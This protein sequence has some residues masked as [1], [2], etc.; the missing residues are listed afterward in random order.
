VEGDWRDTYTGFLLSVIVSKRTIPLI[1]EIL[2]TTR[3]QR[4]KKFK[5][6]TKLY[7]KVSQTISKH[8]LRKFELNQGNKKNNKICPQ[9]HL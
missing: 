5:I 3:I 8:K 2:S 6:K 7:K 4:L 9:F 1:L